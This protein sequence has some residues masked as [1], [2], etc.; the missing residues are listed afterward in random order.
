MKKI[1]EIFW[2][3]DAEENLKNI[4]EHIKK[5]SPKNADMVVAEIIELS[6]ALNFCRS[7]IRNV[8]N[9]RTKQK[10]TGRLLTDLTK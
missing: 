2:S 10:H 6:K 4:Y 3:R 7:V 5:D 1:F 8:L 9:S